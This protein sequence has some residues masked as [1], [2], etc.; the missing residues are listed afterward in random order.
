MKTSI[1]RLLPVALLLAPWVELRASDPP[2]PINEAAWSTIATNLSNR[3]GGSSFVTCA[4]VTVRRQD[5]GGYTAIELTV[6]NHSGMSGSYPGTVFT[7]VG[8]ANLTGIQETPGWITVR[9]D[10]S[11]WTGWEADDRVVSGVKLPRRVGGVETTNGINDGI[12]APHTFVFRFYVTSLGTNYSKW[13]LAIHGQGGPNDCSTKLVVNM[14]GSTNAPGGTEAAG[15]SYTPP[16][17]TPIP[18]PATLVL[19]ATG[20]L[21]L[22]GVTAIRRRNRQK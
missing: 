1:A 20:M 17:P 5:I 10:G 13:Q 3:C 8:I 11:D 7:A 19:F 4:S 21:G 22:G 18:E 9:R 6:T 12:Q 2:P 14:D 15:C 16:P